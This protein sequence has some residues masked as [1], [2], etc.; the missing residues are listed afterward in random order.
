[1]W[2]PRGKKKYKNTLVKLIFDKHN[3]DI[4]G[5]LLKLIFP[6]LF[7]HWTVLLLIRTLL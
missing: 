2:Y 7:V 1:M 4:L 6:L 5:L 3:L